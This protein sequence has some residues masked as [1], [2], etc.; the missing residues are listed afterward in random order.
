MDMRVASEVTG[1]RGESRVWLLAA[2]ASIIAFALTLTL[3]A[4]AKWHV[5]A[6]NEQRA[7]SFL[8]T[9]ELRQTSEDLTR[10]VR[11]YVVT[12]NPR[13]KAQYQEILD[14]RDGKRP[15]PAGLGEVYW[16]LVLDNGR[17]P[18][19]SVEPVAL[20]DLMRSAGFRAD[21][22]ASLAK[23]KA[24]SDALTQ[25][26]FAAMQM[27]EKAATSE[28]RLRATAMLFDGAYDQ[29]KAGIMGPIRQVSLSVKRRTAEEVARAQSTANWL[30]V[31]VALA[32]TAI[33]YLCFRLFVAIGRENR[34]LQKLA[35]VFQVSS[36]G[37]VVVDAGTNR[38]TNANTA[39][40]RVHGFDDDGLLGTNIFDL[41]PPEQ[42]DRAIACSR[43]AA[44]T[45]AAAFES[46]RLRKD[47]SRF[48]CRIRVTQCRDAAG[49]AIFRAATVEDI[50]ERIRAETELRRHRDSLER[51]VQARTADLSAANRRLRATLSALESVGTAIFEADA[52]SGRL[53]YVND[54]AMNLLGYTQ[55]ELLEMSVPDID[56]GM[57]PDVYTGVMAEIRAKGALRFE[58]RQKRK[59]GSAVPVEMSVYHQAAEHGTPD[60]FIAFGVDISERKAAEDAL[61]EARRTAESAAETKANF[62]AYMS[63]E[64]RTPMNAIIGLAHLIRKV[65]L[66]AEQSDRMDRLEAAAKHL[67]EVIN[68]I[69]D[70]SKMEARKFVLEQ[71]PI[72]IE[73]VVAN[74]VS[75]LSDRAAEKNL[76]LFS[77]VQYMPRNL[78]GDATRLQQALINYAN[79]AIKF[80]D[81][82]SVTLRARL[83]TEAQDVAVIRFEVEDTGVGIDA[84]VIP[85]LFT[86]FEQVDS[87]TT[88]AAAGT[89]LG[90]A[91]TRRIAALMGGEAGV[92]STPGSG[93]TFWFTARLEK[94]AQ[95][96][97]PADEASSRDA[98][99]IL[100]RDFAGTRVLLAEDN[101]INVEVARAILEDV[102][103]IVDVAV[104]GVEA[105]AKAIQNS[106][107]LV[108]MDMQM[109]RMDGL[110]A[111]RE[112][113]RHCPS[114]SLPIIAMTANVFAEDQAR[115]YAAGMDDFIGKPVEPD[116]LY[117]VIL[118]WL[119]AA[120]RPRTENSR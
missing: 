19:A 117:E 45:G 83:V 30:L 40:A 73:S 108:L 3:Y 65:G 97:A 50:T 75:M 104:D 7:N 116:R 23:A 66:S 11:A 120:S 26:E 96:E 78:V 90:L 84:A 61:R 91:I 107:R 112:I 86:A 34:A 48:P 20:L 25:T 79:N 76:G 62:L 22:F 103:F 119:E 115:C 27:V 92:Q 118:K 71:R 29:A 31:A 52:G 57:T 21:E 4:V 44:E 114:A 16:D 15:R 49:R 72:R 110:E 60:R 41:F 39:F 85:R 87:S 13:F 47:G 111:T 69:L 8:L 6:A 14:I 18:G 53:T 1:V 80:T 51:T 54:R 109:P 70:L 37:M 24:A 28:T 59:D 17:R 58:T 105:V 55:A 106:Y 94:L 42:R 81:A 64:I 12:G 89:G 67:L 101:E 46:E 113:R 98:A 63:H 33:G 88:R 56:V 5:D 93:S 95:S 2:L 43:E 68:S 9:E 77:D 102:N 99:A 10:M 36:W 82:G 100:R 32:A 74:V 35:A 38:I